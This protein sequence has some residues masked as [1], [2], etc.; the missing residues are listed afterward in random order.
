MAKKP[1]R[2]DHR[3]RY[4]PMLDRLKAPK[5]EWQSNA[6]R[7][8]EEQKE[9][10][11][12]ITR[13][14]Y[15]RH[16]NDQITRNTFS[17]IHERIEEEVYEAIRNNL[18]LVAALEWRVIF[19]D[20]AIHAFK[21]AGMEQPAYVDGILPTDGFVLSE[22]FDYVQYFEPVVTLQ[23]FDNYDKFMRS[24][25]QSISDAEKRRKSGDAYFTD[26]DRAINY[27]SDVGT[28]DSVDE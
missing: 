14:V 21:N 24:A 1:D 27:R 22:L 26:R 15:N 2:F 5:E 4:V 8:T 18:E 13:N 10:V 16:M 23:T 9:K 20:S 7:L 17:K 19:G 6:P 25:E 28:A 3:G 11:Q 12:R